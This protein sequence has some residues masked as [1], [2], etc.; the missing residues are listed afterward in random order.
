MIKASR[1]SRKVSFIRHGESEANA[2]KITYDPA[3]INLTPSGEEQARTIAERFEVVPDLIVMSRYLRTHQTA[4]HLRERYPRVPHAQWDVHE[5]TYLS[6]EK[7]RN[8]TSADRLPDVI[9]YW[10]TCDPDYCDGPGAESFN[11]FMGRVIAM[12][13]TLLSRHEGHIAVFSHHQFISALLWLEGNGSYDRSRQAM[14]AFKEYFQANF[15]PNCGII[16]RDLG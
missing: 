13:Q 14:T 3:I 12:K 2:G 6:P 15:I 4:R 10:D 11:D 8:T 7:C 1:R 5:F 16:E 9:R